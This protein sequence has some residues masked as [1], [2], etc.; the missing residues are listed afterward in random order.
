[1]RGAETVMYGTMVGHERLICSG[2]PRR[3]AGIAYGHAM[4]GTGYDKFTFSLAQDIDISPK[5]MVQICHPSKLGICQSTNPN[6]SL[7]NAEPKNVSRSMLLLII[8]GILHSHRPFGP[9]LVL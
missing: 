3:F 4:Q 8:L 2:P 9:I 7:C 6:A 5:T 1:M